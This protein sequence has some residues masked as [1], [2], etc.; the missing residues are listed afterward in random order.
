M[1]ML[2]SGMKRINIIYI[3]SYKE[4]NCYIVLIKTVHTNIA[5]VAGRG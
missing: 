1:F 5:L 2:D 4:I 3:T